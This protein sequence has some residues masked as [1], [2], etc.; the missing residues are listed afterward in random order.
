MKDYNKLRGGYYTPYEISEFI[1]KWAISD[2][3]ESVLEPSCGDG[4]FIRTLTN[5]YKK[6][7]ATDEQV[8][9]SVLGIEQD[10]IEAEKAS[11]YGATIIH[12]DFFNYYQNNIDGHTRFDVIIGNPP[13]IRCK[14]F[15]EEQR[16][17][18]FDLMKKYGFAPNRLTNIWISFLVLC[19]KALKPNGRVGMVI[20]AELFYVDYAAETREFLNAFFDRLTII[21]FKKL[22]FD[23]IQQDVVLLLGE[24]SCEE[25]GVRLIELDDL[26]DLTTRGMKSLDKAELIDRTCNHWMEYYLTS[27]EI[28]LLKRLDGDSRISNSSELFEVNIGLVS[29]RNEFFIMNKSRVRELDLEKS[30]VPIISQSKQVKGINL[31]DKDY[32]NLVEL[33]K[34]VFFFAPENKDFDDLL[35]EEKSY[36]QLGEKNG[37]NTNYKCRI[38]P[39]W[40]YV[41][42]SWHAEAFMLCNAHLYP[43]LILNKREMLVTNNLHKIKFLEGVDGSLVTAAFLNTYTLAISELTGRGYSGGLLELTPEVIRQ[44]RIP[45]RMAERLD[46]QKIDD[47]QRKGEIDKILE[48]TDSVLL[49]EGLDL[50]NGEIKMLHDIWDK[51]RNKR[52]NRNKK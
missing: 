31:T 48:Y 40:Y 34:D 32:N 26:A 18:A 39:K 8:K 1:T 37:F 3:S 49:R 23:N 46:F 25:R 7:G 6:L 38:R 29:G 9:S 20:P 36:I 43:R 19:C 22:V 17:I 51:L 11:R 13:Y 41:P 27:E 12:D 16:K 52:L 44:L 33:D 10:K 2:A 28:D 4:S 42:Q 14:D 35:D 24:R 47:W 30:V 5:H 21:T 15:K 50:T 45:M